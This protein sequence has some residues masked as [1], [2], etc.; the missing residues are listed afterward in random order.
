MIRT[1]AV[2][3]TGLIGTSL[4]LAAA[5]RG[6]TVYLQDSDASAVRTAA[7]LGAGIPGP[8]PEPVDL[9]VIAV[10]PSLVATVL[11]HHQTRGLACTYTDVASVKS[12]PERAVLAGA[13]DPT[14]YIGG[15]PLAGRERSGPLAAR[16]DL[17]Q[18]RVWV[19]TPSRLTSRTALDR[20]LA[21]IGLCGAVPLVMQSKAH[22]D[23]VALTSHVPHVVSS[24]MA[25]RL[26]HGPPQ[27][28]RLAGQG[29]RDVTRIAG[30]DSRLWSD[31]LQANA[32]AVA[33]VLTDLQSDLAE[34][35][36]ALNDLAGPAGRRSA[37]SLPTVVD[38]LD[39]GI[40]GLDEMSAGHP[41]RPPRSASVRVRIADRPGELSRL[42]TAT[43]EL[44]VGPEDAE[45]RPG[46]GTHG[47][48][49]V[50]LSVPAAVTGPLLARVTAEGWDAD[51]DGHPAH[52][53]SGT[54][55]GG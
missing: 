36:T 39:R 18:D 26:R 15:H 21:L 46:D 1:L 25:A 54:P 28:P 12:E 16:V 4:A 20:A 8:P 52:A 49:A 45:V 2:V 37:Q 24:L 33:G 30:G 13:P 47:D 3:G 38:L 41:G 32:G 55:T 50:R 40:T 43:A 42:L 9:A 53:A 35:L 29:L 34:L 27:A 22:D 48:L 17:F 51:A 44:G 5:R 10:P 7:A 19:L 11:A 14:R 31:I 6:V 23:A